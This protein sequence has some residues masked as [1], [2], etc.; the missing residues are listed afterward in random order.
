M[1][2]FFSAGLCAGLPTI[3][4]ALYRL[5]RHQEEGGTVSAFLVSLIVSNILELVLNPF[6]ITCFLQRSS[7]STRDVLLL[8]FAEARLCGL[9]FH[10]LVALEG[11][12]CLTYPHSSSHFFH[13][14][15]PPALSLTVWITVISCNFFFI[16]HIINLIICLVSVILAFITSALTSRLWSLSAG[17]LMQ[18]GFKVFVTAML[19]LIILYI[20]CLV[21]YGMNLL[22][23]R[24]ESSWDNG[25]VAVMSLRL[26]TEPVLCV[27]VCGETLKC[28]PPQRQQGSS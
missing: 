25:A 5:R 7:C 23:L 3:V 17:L 9:H 24:S 2:L 19:T 22:Y 20:P 26:V 1:S 10:Q 15:L 11:I 12:L 14:F 28:Q 21:I 8:S 18:P 27:L 6:L 16:G 13:V 4:W